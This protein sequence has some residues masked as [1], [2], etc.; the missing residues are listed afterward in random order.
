MFS[1]VEFLRILHGHVGL[2]A[3][4]LLLH[5]AFTLGRL[6]NGRPWPGLRWSAGLGTAAV[7]LTFAL[8]WWLYPAYR[9]E[10]KPRLLADAHGLAMAFETKEH[11]AFYAVALALGGAGLLWLGETRESRR[12][13]RW[14][15]GLAGALVAVNVLLGSAVGSFVEP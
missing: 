11:L 12:L 2:L 1:A 13:C 4:A 15:Y 10:Q 9:A 14:C 7:T 3:A 5:P 6:K 8:G